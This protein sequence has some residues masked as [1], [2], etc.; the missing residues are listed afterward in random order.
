MCGDCCRFSPALRRL[1]RF[2][3]AGCELGLDQV[4]GHAGLRL[5]GSRKK[6]EGLGGDQTQPLVSC[7]LFFL[8]FP[9][10]CV[11]L[12]P[13]HH[14]HLCQC[15][16]SSDREPYATLPVCLPPQLHSSGLPTTSHRQ[17]WT[18]PVCHRPRGLCGW[19][20]CF[21]CSCP[22]CL[23]LQGCGPVCICSHL[24]GGECEY[25]PE[26]TETKY[27]TPGQT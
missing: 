11:F 25:H 17:T 14:I 27:Q 15:W 8:S 18:G 5:R 13:L 24:Y 22:T 26:R 9:S 1:V 7:H 21:G 2:L 6:D 16:T 20:P 23:P 10:R 19:Q 4:V 3:G 12:W